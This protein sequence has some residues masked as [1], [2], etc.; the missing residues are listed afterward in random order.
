MAS[1]IRS[2]VP[3]HSPIWCVDA[4]I[5][6]RVYMFSESQRLTHTYRLSEQLN[7]VICNIGYRQSTRQPQASL[8]KTKPSQSPHE[9]KKVCM[10]SVVYTMHS[11]VANNWLSLRS[12]ARMATLNRIPGHHFSKFYCFFFIWQ[13]IVLR[14]DGYR[15]AC[16]GF[17]DIK[18]FTKLKTGVNN[19]FIAGHYQTQTPADTYWKCDWII[20][21]EF[22][23]VRAR[24]RHTPLSVARNLFIILNLAVVM[25]WDN[26]SHLMISFFCFTTTTTA[27]A[28]LSFIL[29]FIH[30][31]C[32]NTRILSTKKLSWII[33]CGNL[34]GKHTAIWPNGYKVNV[35]IGTFEH[36]KWIWQINFS[37]EPVPNSQ[38]YILFDDIDVVRLGHAFSGWTFEIQ[39]MKP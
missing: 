24:G 30:S 18:R 8:T 14:V 3:C 29:L 16:I 36:E 31:G 6:H 17:G 2:R 27:T 12:G 7:T 35:N 33:V 10:N 28:T 11:K 39:I 15:L 21:I 34:V 22:W 1:T 4:C 23:Y 9:K 26:A 13:C 20:I 19:Q 37:T 32:L 5:V 38:I 25:C